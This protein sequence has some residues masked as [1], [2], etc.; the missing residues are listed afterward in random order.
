MAGYQI[1]SLSEDT[2]FMELMLQLRGFKSGFEI[3]EFIG[4]G[5]IPYFWKSMLIKAELKK[6]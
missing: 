2:M 1:S 4:C 5:R 6:L 3:T